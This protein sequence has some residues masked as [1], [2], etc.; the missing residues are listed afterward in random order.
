[1][2]KLKQEGNLFTGF[3]W[4]PLPKHQLKYELEFGENQRNLEDFAAPSTQ[5][6]QVQLEEVFYNRVMPPTL[7]KTNDFTFPFQQIVNTYGIPSYKEI[8]P[9]IFT[10]VTFPFLF[11]V[12]F[13]DIGHGSALFVFGSILCL[14]ASKIEIFV[15]SAA[16]LL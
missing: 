13:G 1:M 11:A 10:C 9:A 4:S 8:N 5:Q 6:A 7:F 15:P 3:L 2:N 14:F 12:M 16:P